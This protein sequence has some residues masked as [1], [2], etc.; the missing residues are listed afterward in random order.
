MIQVLK[1][2]RKFYTLIEKLYVSVKGFT[3]TLSQ[4]YAHIAQQIK[5]ILLQGSGLNIFIIHFKSVF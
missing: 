4:I 1:S 3:D 2:D 5:L